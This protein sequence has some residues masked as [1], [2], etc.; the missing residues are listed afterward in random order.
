MCLFMPGV[1]NSNKQEDFNK[2]ALDF[3]K[4]FDN[5][6][7][8]KG[9]TTEFLTENLFT[10]TGDSKS[11]VDSVLK[12]TN[13]AAKVE[14]SS[15]SSNLIK[16]SN[17]IKKVYNY[18]KTNDVESKGLHKQFK[19]VYENVYEVLGDID[20]ESPDEVNSS[21]YNMIL[22]EAQNYLLSKSPY[23]GIDIGKMLSENLM[24]K[25]EIFI[26][27]IFMILAN[28]GVQETT[29]GEKVKKLDEAT[30]DAIAE[31]NYGKIEKPYM[32][33]YYDGKKR[34][35]DMNPK[36]MDWIEKNYIG[37]I[38]KIE[39]LRS[40]MP[41]TLSEKI[42]LVLDKARGKDISTA[43]SCLNKAFFGKDK[44]KYINSVEDWKGYINSNLGYVDAI[45]RGRVKFVDEG[46]WHALEDYLVFGGKR[47]GVSMKNSDHGVMHAKRATYSIDDVADFI[48]SN[49]ELFRD[50]FCT[51]ITRS[52]IEL[53]KYA[54]LCHD[55]DRKNHMTDIFDETSAHRAEKQLSKV[56][57]PNQIKIV[58]DAM[59]N[60]DANIRE[61]SRIAILLHEADCIEYQRLRGSGDYN[62]VFLDLYQILC[63]AGRINPKTD[64]K[65]NNDIVKMLFDFATGTYK[66]SVAAQGVKTKTKVDMSEEERKF[67]KK[68]YGSTYRE[69]GAK[70]REQF[71]GETPQ[72][73]T[74]ERYL[75]LNNFWDK[76]IF[77]YNCLVNMGTRNGLTT[78]LIL[79]SMITLQNWSVTNKWVNTVTTA[80][81]MID[82]LWFSKQYTE[83][84]PANYV[85][86]PNNKC[87]YKK[88]FSQLKEFLEQN[89]PKEK[90]FLLNGFYDGDIYNYNYVVNRGTYNGITNY[91][92]LPNAVT[93]QNFSM[94][95]R[96][97]SV[98]IS[99]KK[100][101]EDLLSKNSYVEVDPHRFIIN[102]VFDYNGY[103]SKISSECEKY[104]VINGFYDQT[105]FNY[106]YV[107][108]MGMDFNTSLYCL[109]PTKNWIQSFVK[110]NP[111]LGWNSFNF[112]YNLQQ[113]IDNCWM[114]GM[115]TPINPLSIQNFGDVVD[116][117]VYIGHITQELSG[118]I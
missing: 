68:T 43:I 94:R 3:A 25:L 66:K 106:N 22:D 31:R 45:G 27:C 61:K 41:M 70:F 23:S 7:N 17:N 86:N 2:Q 32:T 47:V 65:D 53:A 1:D 93:L 26:V 11:F 73:R 29:N 28:Q 60:K 115:T 54:A 9:Y 104:F 114:Q 67:L 77:N 14:G 58:I 102:N 30:V 12:N 79:P 78:Y 24:Y 96:W 90:Y 112:N 100:M 76:D 57:K 52:E 59:K 35:W 80:K 37:D 13:I 85:L 88:Y 84:N 15:L 39:H 101:I 87:D 113:F 72:S 36:I 92:I 74:G 8:L 110:A 40:L 10:N 107:V 83:V 116:K 109:L 44:H 55:M 64:N 82:K 48:N 51:P 91:L 69:R 33:L 75:T 38:K 105:I 20:D 98:M 21:K 103:F 111:Q 118:K 81:E 18:L 56:L 16:F 34:I 4:S 19:K 42:L 50:Y 5:S 89:K 108:K 99:A 49:L 62:P 97:P 71:G 63:Q 117:Q 95:N 6:F 46:S